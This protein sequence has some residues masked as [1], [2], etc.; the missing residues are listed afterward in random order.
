MVHE[1]VSPK[2][3]HKHKNKLNIK[4]NIKRNCCVRIN[5][6]FGRVDVNFNIC[7]TKERKVNRRKV[8]LSKI[9]RFATSPPR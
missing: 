8:N 2:D 6:N 1:M 3:K 9:D 7:E 4:E 5:D